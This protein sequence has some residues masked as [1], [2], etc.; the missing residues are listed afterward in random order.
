MS[1]TP[2]GCP[3][4]PLEKITVARSSGRCPPS[5][6]TKYSDTQPGSSSRPSSV[7]S[8]SNVDTLGSRSSR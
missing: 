1:I 2:L 4:L 5:R 8:L 7:M 6:R 3:V